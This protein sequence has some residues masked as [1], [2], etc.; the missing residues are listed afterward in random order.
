M[1]RSLQPPARQVGADLPDLDRPT[2]ATCRPLARFLSIDDS[3]GDSVSASCW[4]S[5]CPGDYL[6]FQIK[7]HD[8]HAVPV[9]ENPQPSALAPI[10]SHRHHDQTLA[11]G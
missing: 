10:H 5:A 11:G 8:R 7:I 4:N 3:R 9:P 1:W 2:L 6:G